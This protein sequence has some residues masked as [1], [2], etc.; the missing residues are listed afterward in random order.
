MWM[1]TSSENSRLLTCSGR[2]KLRLSVPPKPGSQS[3]H[4]KLAWVTN[5]ARRSQGSM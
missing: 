2:M 5:W 1:N 4:S 3:I